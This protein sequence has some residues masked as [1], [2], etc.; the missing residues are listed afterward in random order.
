MVT[1]E[2]SHRLQRAVLWKASGFDNNGKVT[3]DPAEEIDVRWVEKRRG[4]LDAQGNTIAVDATAVVDQEIVVG[5]ILWLGNMDD[6][7]AIPVNLK[8]VA[9]YDETPDLR[10]RE[11]A[12]SVGLV[13]YS[14]TLPSLT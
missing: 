8:Q 3:V 6:L 10:G 13:R 14:E 4:T 12:R 11:T 1:V 2:T 5:S 9:T 7:P